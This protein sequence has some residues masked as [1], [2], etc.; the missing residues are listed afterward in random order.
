MSVDVLDKLRDVHIP[1]EPSVW[2]LAMGYW[3]LI[4]IILFIVLFFVLFFIYK[5]R[6]KIIFRR[7]LLKEINTYTAKSEVTALLR[8]LAA[9]KYQ[10]PLLKNKDIFSILPK[11]SKIFKNKNKFE[12]LIDLLTKDRFKPQNNNDIEEIIK[13]TKELVKKCKL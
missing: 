11:L 13:L 12:K 8:R 10:D 4:A 5:I 1:N 6:P 7:Y 3:I 9:K 2:P